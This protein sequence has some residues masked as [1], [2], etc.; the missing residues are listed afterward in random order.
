MERGGRRQTV[1]PKRYER[2]LRRVVA[3]TLTVAWKAV[4]NDHVAEFDND[5]MGNE[6]RRAARELSERIETVS[7]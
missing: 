6:E 5:D 4:E 1:S 2:Y 3:G 7:M